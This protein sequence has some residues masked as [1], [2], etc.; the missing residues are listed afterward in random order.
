M[1]AEETT[2]P[3]GEV[4]A[5]RP[6]VALLAAIIV[7][8]IGAAVAFLSLAEADTGSYSS[9]GFVLDYGPTW[10]R[11]PDERCPTSGVFGV[12]CLLVLEHSARPDLVVSFSQTALNQ[13][14]TINDLEQEAAGFMASG[15]L[16]YVSLDRITL[17]DVPALR[18]IFYTAMPGTP[19]GIAYVTQI[20]VPRPGRMIGLTIWTPGQVVYNQYE[21]DINRLLLS[22][23]WE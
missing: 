8:A 5:A 19:Q 15:G 1:S 7:M 10:S 18:T 22:L 17:D 20:Q 4:P 3:Q 14:L 21:R 16:E 6:V 2:D 13:P 12:D 23:R 9:G 11:L